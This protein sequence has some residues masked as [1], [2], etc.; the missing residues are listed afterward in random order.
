MARVSLDS[1]DV[2]A[3]VPELQ[4]DTAV[5]QAV[6]YHRTK[7]VFLN[8]I[9]EQFGDQT[10]RTGPAVILS[11]HE[12][13]ILILTSKQLLQSGLMPMFSYKRAHNGFGNINVSY[14]A[15]RFGRFPHKAG[16]AFAGL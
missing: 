4:A 7:T 16:C 2:T 11:D 8:H 14:A 9:V 6:E 3:A 13:I 5:T 12:I 15:L 10:G 1:L